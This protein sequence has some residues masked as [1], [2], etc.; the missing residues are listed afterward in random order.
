[1][2]KDIAKTCILHVAFVKENLIASLS[3]YETKTLRH[4]E[5]L[6][7]TVVHR[8]SPSHIRE[9]LKKKTPERLS[10]WGRIG[11]TNLDFLYVRGLKTL[12]SLLDIKLDLVALVQGSIAFTTNSLKV[13]ENIFAVLTSD[14][15][16]ALGSVEPFDRSFFHG[17]LPFGKW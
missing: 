13:D 5:K 17:T 14:E 7:S 9:L 8:Y 10:H 1:L 12:G 16:E 11:K 3:N 15:A 6:N 2:R 4:I